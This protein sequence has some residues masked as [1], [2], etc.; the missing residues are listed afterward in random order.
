MPYIGHA[1]YQPGAVDAHGNS[2]DAWADPVQV[3][4]DG[5]GPR[6][7]SVE[8]GGSQVI[9]GLQVFIPK[10]LAVSPQDRFVIGSQTYTVEGE[11]G[12]WNHGPFGFEPGVVVN[13]KR[14]EGGV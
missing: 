6:T 10:G 12:D 5:Y 2:S 13:V 11:V 8:P 4:V 9:V 7:D 3:W 14:V 1:V